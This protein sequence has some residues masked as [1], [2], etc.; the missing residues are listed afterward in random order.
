MNEPQTN[1]WIQHVRNSLGDVGYYYESAFCTETSNP[2]PILR[3]AKLLGNL[4]VPAG[5]DA[6]QPVILTRPSASAPA[7]HPFNRNTAIGWHNDFSTRS[8]RPELSFSWIRQEDPS[9]PDKGA[10]RVASV[11]AVLRKLRE[12]PEGRRLIGNLV[13]NAQPFGYGDAGDWHPF[14]VIVRPN[15]RLSKTG[16]RFYGRA[17]REGALLRYGIVP[18]NTHQII[19][20]LEEVADTVGEVLRASIGS[21]LIVD[22]RFSLHD[23]TQQRTTGREKQRRQAWLCFVKRLDRPL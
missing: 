2:E 10:W 14:R 17:L 7:W 16:M 11:T 20:Q 13:S 19:T 3:A 4:Y 22:N 6:K 23:R 5:M 9:G 21:L 8:G 15:R 1:E 12:T 18:E